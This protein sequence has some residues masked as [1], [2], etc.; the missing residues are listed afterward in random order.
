MLR[1]I[2]DI[3]QLLSGGWWNLH[4][5]YRLHAKKTVAA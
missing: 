2:A 3:T 4:A 1:Q 5:D